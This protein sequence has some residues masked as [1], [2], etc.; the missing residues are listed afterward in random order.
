MTR[1]I[2]DI[3]ISLDGFVTGPDAG[4]GN[5]LGTGGAPIHGWVLEQPRS[6]VDEA[7]LSEGFGRTGAVIMGRNLFD[8]IDAP[9]GWNDEVGYGHDQD[10]S[11]LPPCFVV[12]HAVP[13]QVRLKSR[14]EF[15]TEGVAAAIER[16]RAAAGDRDVVIMGGASIVDQ[17]LAEH[18]ADELRIHLS[19]VVMGAGTRLFTLTGPTRLMQ[20][21]V[22]VSPRATH[23]AYDV[24]KP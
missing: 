7:I 11:G 9:G 4:P 14:F 19:P 1:V 20:R 10:Q 13:A 2:A 12:T 5:G 6:E 18:L 3:S 21:E 15:V 24:V 8:V 22:R 23:I 17:S 16:G